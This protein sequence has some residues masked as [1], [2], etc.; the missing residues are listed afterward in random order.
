MT[1]RKNVD[2]YDY[3]NIYKNA[4][5]ILKPNINALMSYTQLLC[6]SF[7]FLLKN[8]FKILIRNLKTI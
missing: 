7:I 3:D 2:K 1:I 5:Q 6:F 8:F 4:L